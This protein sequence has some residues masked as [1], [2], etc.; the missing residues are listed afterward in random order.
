M[1]V[2]LLGGAGYLGSALVPQLL[3]RN[4][5]VIVYDLLWFGNNLPKEATVYKKNI[6]D[7]VSDDLSNADAVVFIAGV[8]NDPM[9]EYSPAINFMGNAAA[10]AYA[11]Y[12]TKKCGIKRFVYA[13]SCSIYG[14][15]AGEAMTEEASVNPSF[16]YGISKLQ[17]ESAVMMMEDK[18]F[19]PISLRKG[20][21]Y[22]WSPRMRYDLVVNTMLK[23]ALTDHKI[24]VHNPGL[25]RPLISTSD[26][27]RAYIR[28]IEADP[29]ISGIYNISYDNYTIGRLA[30]EVCAELRTHNIN[31]IDLDIQNRHDFRNY[32]VSHEK[33]RIELDFVPEVSPRDAVKEV[34]KK[35]L[36]E[37]PAQ[38][39]N[40]KFAT[41]KINYNNREWF[42]YL[43]DS[44]YYNIEVFKE[45]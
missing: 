35:I 29:S 42:K 24:T 14:Y 1:R 25:W 10:P 31:N 36:D 40:T 21:I 44:K 33:A 32:K 17:G 12:L 38:I 45:L 8:S 9:A 34:L 19:K 2:I 23:C 27:A 18:S 15:T 26:A 28:A 16:P 6:L 13:S 39:S 22:G 7:L 4:Y 11:A 20:T 5:E 41:K 3:K 37:A 43:N 30:D